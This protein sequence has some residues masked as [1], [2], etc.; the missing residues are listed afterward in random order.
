M[1][2]GSTS[3][4]TAVEVVMALTPSTCS[5]WRGTG[6]W[7]DGAHAPHG[8]PL[9]DGTQPAVRIAATAPWPGEGARREPARARVVRAAAAAAAGM[10]DKDASQRDPV[11]H[12]VAE[13]RAGT[14]HPH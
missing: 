2:Q 12:V 4:R 3:C 9:R 10:P 1:M 11:R 5:G 13:H 7:R 14:D 6:G 8:C